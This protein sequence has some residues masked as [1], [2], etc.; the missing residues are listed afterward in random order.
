MSIKYIDAKYQ[1]INIYKRRTMDKDDSFDFQIEGL[2][3]ID[4][5][6]QQH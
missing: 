2:A 3:Q 6:Y 5:F 1:I 4:H